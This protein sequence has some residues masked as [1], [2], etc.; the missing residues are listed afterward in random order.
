[1]WDV[2]KKAGAIIRP[3]L[4]KTGY[5]QKY[6]VQYLPPEAPY[7]LY[8]KQMEDYSHPQ[9]APERSSYKLLICVVNGIVQ[10]VTVSIAAFPDPGKIHDR[11]RFPFCGIPQDK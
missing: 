3:S 8:Q 7:P 6:S 4:R 1:M 2:N 11:F 5:L 10:G 9:K